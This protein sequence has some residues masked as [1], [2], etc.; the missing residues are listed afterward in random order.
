MCS[1][2]AAERAVWPMPT[3]ATLAVKHHLASVGAGQTQDVLADVVEYHLP[4]DGYGA[5]HPD[6]RPHGD[7]VDIGAEAAAAVHL[8]GQ[9][10]ALGGGLR[11]GELR[12]VSIRCCRDLVTAIEQLGG[13]AGHERGQLQV[14]LGLGQGVLQA[15][16]GADGLIEHYPLPGVSPRLLLPHL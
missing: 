15:L 12:H 14:C 16:M 11:G 1:S 3:M 7:E 5:Q 8:D 6:K 13:V 10:A 2:S 9:I 4:G